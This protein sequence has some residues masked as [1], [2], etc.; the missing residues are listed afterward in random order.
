MPT[1]PPKPCSEPRCYKMS[2]NSGRCEDHQPE[3]WLSSKGKTPT[4]RGYGYDWKKLRLKVLIRDAHLCQECFKNN[5]IT[6]AT[7]VDHIIPKSKGGTNAMTNLQSLCNPCH[8]IK[9]NS[10]RKEK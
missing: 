1:M 4:E 9:T 8:K 5:I 10:E 6:V 7:D 3:P 2:S